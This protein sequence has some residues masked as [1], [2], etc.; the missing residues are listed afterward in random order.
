MA[1]ASTDGV[2]DDDDIIIPCQLNIGYNNRDGSCMH[3]CILY[4]Y[5]HHIYFYCYLNLSYFHC[6]LI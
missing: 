1:A 5:H 2:I 6:Y 3:N 4:L